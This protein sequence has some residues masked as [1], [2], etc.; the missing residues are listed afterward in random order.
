MDAVWWTMRL[1]GWGGDG[2]ETTFANSPDMREKHDAMADAEYN[3]DNLGDA[4]QYEPGE[5]IDI[6]VSLNEALFAPIRG[7]DA[8]TKYAARAPTEEEYR[9]VFGDHGSGVHV[10]DAANR[11]GHFP[12]SETRYGVLGAG[13][14]ADR[15]ADAAR[16]RAMPYNLRSPLKIID[17]FTGIGGLSVGLHMLFPSA[18]H[19]LF[20]DWEPHTQ[21]VIKSLVRGGHLDDA[22]RMD[23]I[24][25]ITEH[26]LSDHR[27]HIVAG[28]FPCQDISKG[29]NKHAA[30]S[31]GKDVGV[32]GA[33]SGMFYQM[34][35]V[36]IEVGADWVFLE[37][38]S[39]IVN[40]G[41]PL[42]L[43]ELARLNYDAVWT[44]VA[45]KDVG[46]PH[47]RKRFFCLAR[48]R[49]T[50]ERPGLPR[51]LGGG[52]NI[53]E[54]LLHETVN[55]WA[56]QPPPM[57]LPV[58]TPETEQRMARL[59]NAVVPLQAALAFARL[60]DMYG[61]QDSQQ[62]ED[63]YEYVRPTREFAGD[64]DKFYP[65]ARQ[66]YVE[67]VRLKGA[68]LDLETSGVQR[69]SPEYRLLS[70]ELRGLQAQF[71][72]L[73]ERVEAPGERHGE[74]VHRVK[75]G[76]RARHVGTARHTKPEYIH[77]QRP[78][79]VGTIMY[80]QPFID[81]YLN[82]EQNGVAVPPNLKLPTDGYMDGGT[83]FITTHRPFV[84][85]EWKR[86]V[87]P[88]ELLTMATP[89]A[90][91]RPDEGSVR[92]F[93][94]LLLERPKQGQGD[95]VKGCRDYWLRNT[96]KALS[97][98]AA[99]LPTT[100][101]EKD[102]G[103]VDPLHD[104]V[105]EAASIAYLGKCSF[106]KQGNIPDESHKHNCVNHEGKGA[107]AFSQKYAVYKNPVFTEWLMGFA[108]N[109]TDTGRTGDADKWTFKPAA[110]GK[111]P[112]ATRGKGRGAA[113][114]DTA[115]AGGPPLPPRKP[116]D[117]IDRE[118][119]ARQY[120][121]EATRRQQTPTVETTAG[122]RRTRA[123]RSEGSSSYSG[124]SGS[125]GFVTKAPKR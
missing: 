20:A 108:L 35:D 83:R 118:R 87:F 114:W 25:K 64:D 4:A 112:T 93:R 47:E 90:N 107:A 28:G 34:L 53:A 7:I 71:D 6:D 38:V 72:A 49:P 3:K 124:S 40:A 86:P 43:A 94:W 97:R 55:P 31:Q 16:R 42:V 15:N 70:V 92:T 27:P 103:I 30:R 113:A 100:R 67:I 29:Y 17:L 36:A 85:T 119:I 57:A 52:R 22:L 68:I 69:E 105:D 101:I 14:A 37:N 61:D 1:L 78:T 74:R 63:T 39:N 88:Q 77:Q 66:L 18:Q 11:W 76:R 8:L 117:Q 56:T 51:P 95:S 99:E 41:L 45:A 5:E 62:H 84:D 115:R 121:R 24:T 10:V 59:G 26:D 33:R 50:A 32:Q 111:P 2:R 73:A 60:L 102:D 98:S 91:G 104:A 12:V 75:T 79:L 82:K 106:L 48:R 13:V 123:D 19:V 110:G 80:L 109:W 89:V 116:H 46:A 58:K 44:I 9:A 81:A 21:Q 23:D 54:M 96:R 120:A 125:L 65:A 122:A